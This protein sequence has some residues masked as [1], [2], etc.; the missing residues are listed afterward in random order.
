MAYHSRGMLRA[1]SFLPQVLGA[2]NQEGCQSPVQLGHSEV[3]TM[4]VVHRLGGDIWSRLVLGTVDLP[5][6][7]SHRALVSA[8]SSSTPSGR[9]RSCR[10]LISSLGSISWFASRPIAILINPGD[11]LPNRRRRRSSPAQT[12]YRPM[13]ERRMLLTICTRQEGRP[14]APLFSQGDKFDAAGCLYY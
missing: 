11:K 3:C 14:A 9:V 2:N 1:Y 10:S 5:F 7:S 8:F 12:E 6:S 4:A 13:A